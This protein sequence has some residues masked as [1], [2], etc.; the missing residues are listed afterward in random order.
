M[1]GRGPEVHRLRNSVEE[2]K[3]Q[4]NAANETLRS[5]RKE[6]ENTRSIEREELQAKK[7]QIQNDITEQKNFLPSYTSQKDELKDQINE[8][9]TRTSDK[10]PK[11]SNL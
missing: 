7:N 1:L 11:K 3:K 6:L 8:R 10:S 9:N 4:L 5:D 2:A